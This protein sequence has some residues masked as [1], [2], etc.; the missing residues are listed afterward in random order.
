M[1]LRFT[2][3]ADKSA[4]GRG[5]LFEC[6]VQCQRCIGISQ[7]SGTRCK[8]TCCIGVPYCW[9]HLLSVAHLR[10][11]DSTVAGAGKGLFCKLTSRERK[12]RSG[13]RARTA[14]LV[15]FR[16][17]NVIVP[18]HG[19]LINERELVNRYDEKSIDGTRVV[20]EYTAPYAARLNRRQVVDAACKRG[21]G[22]LANHKRGRQA[23]A[24]LETS[25]DGRSIVLVA[26]KNIYDGDEIFV[27]YGRNY[28]L[29]ENVVA[30]THRTRRNR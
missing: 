22:A 3:K 23:N 14:R 12:R 25:A 17:G 27:D 1:P 24:T 8:R 7:R 19:Q 5:V 2:F 29:D 26:T 20:T 28:R 15:V 30:K 10:I 16:R 13:G 4:G 18:Y 6:D 21:A 9:Q 11:K